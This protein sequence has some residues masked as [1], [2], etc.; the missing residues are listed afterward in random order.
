MEVEYQAPHSLVTTPYTG[1]QSVSVREG[2]TVMIRCRWEGNPAA[3]VVW[4]R[5]GVP[6]VWSTEEEVVLDK[7]GKEQAGVYT[8]TAHNSLGVSSPKEIVLNV[9]CK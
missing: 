5:A 7:V 6:G 9:E 4:R 8:C 2:E 3:S 1:D